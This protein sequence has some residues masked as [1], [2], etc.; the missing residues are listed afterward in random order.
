VVLVVANN[1]GGVGKTAITQILISYAVCV[2]GLNTLGVDGDRQGNLSRRTVKDDRVE[3]P[4]KYFPPIHPDYDENKYPT[5]DG[6]S[7]LASI[8]LKD[9]PVAAYPSYQHENFKVI[10]SHSSAL[11]KIEMNDVKLNMNEDELLNVP[12][13]FFN[14]ERMGKA[15]FDLVIADTAPALSPTTLGLLRAS[16][17]VLMPFQLE[18]KSCEGLTAMLHCLHEQNEAKPRSRA[19]KLIGFLANQK[20]WNKR[21]NQE[22]QREKL[23]E[24][25]Y[26]K[27][28]LIPHEIRD[29]S[30]MAK[31]DTK[32]ADLS[33]PFS[34]L[35]SD[36][37]L[38]DDAA[39]ACN[40]IF[41]KL[42]FE[43]LVEEKGIKAE[44][45]L[46]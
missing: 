41:K 26:V 15:G 45:A 36:S 32:G 2:L 46:A 8:Y 40:Y 5:W 37:I 43:K 14:P 7:S 44:E 18:E 30:D 3:I 31:I 21:S 29:A 39:N 12:S 4:S 34:G 20:S 22:Y 11:A 19:S 6:V 33:M 24:S 23:L 38:R 17:H 9:Q 16:T 1:K 13:K 28:Y 10:P 42:G 25:S 35:S 27:D